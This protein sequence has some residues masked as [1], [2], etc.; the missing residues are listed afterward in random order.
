MIEL[1]WIVLL[2]KVGVR[3]GWHELCGDCVLASERTAVR[4]RYK[5]S[6]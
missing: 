5:V 3:D 1:P 4:I 6:I 2:K